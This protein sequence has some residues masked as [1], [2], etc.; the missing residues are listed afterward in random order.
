MQVIFLNEQTLKVIDHAFATDDFEIV[1]DALIP[2][3]STFNIKK[4]DLK[5][6]IG[7]YLVVRRNSYSYIGIISSIEKKNET[8]IKIT[9]KDFLSKFDVEVPVSSYGGSIAQFIINLINTH[10]RSS[11]DAKQNLSY[12]QTEVRVIK[13]GSL[14]YEP[15]TKKNILKLMEEFTKTYGI[16]LV[17]E[18]VIT[19]GVITNIKLIAKDVT[20]GI[21]IKSDLGTISNLTISDS[22]NNALNKIIFTPKKENTLYRTTVAYYLLSDGTITTSTTAVKRI[23][24]V[25]FKYEFYADN[26]YSS[27]LTKATSALIDSSLEHNITFDFSFVANKIA[28]LTELS[29]GTFVS[30]ITPIK[31]YD[32]LV[33]KITYKGTFNQATIVLGEYR[34]SLTDKLKL[35]NRRGG[36]SWP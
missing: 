20:K 5:A 25:S 7:D 15:D 4:E 8:V 22:N 29:L 9:T 35:I 17:Y 18:L 16:G 19:N 3:S 36:S 14:N 6:S 13:T 11:G 30:F 10:F 12:L 33:T 24:N 31:T 27:L 32:T 21:I 23:D 28:A 34:T 1:L 26:D 2:Q